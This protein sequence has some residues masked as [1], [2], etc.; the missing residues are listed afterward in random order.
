MGMIN[1]ESEDIYRKGLVDGANSIT[2]IMLLFSSGS[3]EEITKFLNYI[4]NIPVKVDIKEVKDR[5]GMT[6][7][8]LVEKEQDLVNIH[9]NK[10]DHCVITEDMSWGERELVDERRS[11]NQWEVNYHNQIIDILRKY[12]KIVGIVSLNDEEFKQCGLKELKEIL[13]VIADGK[14][15]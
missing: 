5:N 3:F 1:K 12:Q 10:I 6:I 2:K 15:N 9:Q 8:E 13:E 4:D 14:T 11:R 7:E